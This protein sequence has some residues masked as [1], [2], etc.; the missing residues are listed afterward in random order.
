MKLFWPW[1]TR[2]WGLVPGLPLRGWRYERLLPDPPALLL[3]ACSPGLT[4]V[5]K[6]GLLIPFASTWNTCPLALAICD[7]ISSLSSRFEDHAIREDSHKVDPISKYTAPQYLVHPRVGDTSLTTLVPAAG[8]TCCVI[9]HTYHQALL[10]KH[11]VNDRG[12][13]SL[14]WQS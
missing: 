3:P 1:T 10:T 2:S 13:W 12:Q 5:D 11:C 8:C 14:H 7:V 6:Q 4:S 9:L